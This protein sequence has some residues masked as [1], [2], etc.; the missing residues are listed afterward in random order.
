VALLFCMLSEDDSDAVYV[1]ASVNEWRLG[2]IGTA[3]VQSPMH[4]HICTVV[5]SRNFQF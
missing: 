2:S 1:S 4:S 3:G 5:S